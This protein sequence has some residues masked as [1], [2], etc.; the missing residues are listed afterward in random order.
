MKPVD[1]ILLAALLIM[2]V[3]GGLNRC[4]KTTKSDSSHLDSTIIAIEKQ[5]D[6]I[7]RQVDSANHQ[8]DSLRK[9]NDSLQI[10]INQYS[11]KMDS[12]SKLKSHAIDKISTLNPTESLDYFS[13]WASDPQ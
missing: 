12:L 3:I 2:I 8:L 7:S 6:R 5:F 9:S 13:K 4:N 1:Y 10:I 11:A